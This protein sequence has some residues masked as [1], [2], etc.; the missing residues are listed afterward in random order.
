MHVVKGR[1][2]SMPGEDGVPY[3][4]W[5]VPAAAEALYACYRAFFCNLGLGTPS[6]MKK[7]IMVFPP[8]EN[9]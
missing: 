5:E 6:G 7:S 1:V 4:A 9:L 8:Q 3:S 2:D